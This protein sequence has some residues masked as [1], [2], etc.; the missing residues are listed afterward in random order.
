[1]D[2]RPSITAT[3]MM[4]TGIVLAL[5]HAVQEVRAAG[6]PALAAVVGEFF[7][8]ALSLVTNTLSF[9]RLAAFALNH[10]ALSLALF[11]VVD[12]IPTSAAWLPVRILVF[13]IG[14]ALL[15]VLDTL[16]ISIQTIRLEFYEGLTRYYRGDGRA[17]RPLQFTGT[18]AT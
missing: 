1:L 16:L 11:L 14:S 8:E 4:G 17:Y 6:T 10:G 15:L 12:M 13:V 2:E 9:L 18:A 3:S 5:M 7:H